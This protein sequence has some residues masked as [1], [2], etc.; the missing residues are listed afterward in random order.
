M[1]ELTH[2]VVYVR[3]LTTPVASS[4]SFHTS[5]TAH[6]LCPP[7]TRKLPVHCRATCC[8]WPRKEKKLLV[9]LNFPK[10]TSPRLTGNNPE[11]DP[12]ESQSGHLTSWL[13]YFTEPT[14]KF[15][16]STSIMPWPSPSKSFLI[17]LFIS[18][19]FVRRCIFCDTDA[20][21][22]NPRRK[23]RSTLCMSVRIRDFR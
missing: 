10:L 21:L 6:Q 3:N 23:R 1:T 17:S 8:L 4:W 9:A 18:R 14:D 13:R 5:V 15:W 11:C 12:F 20:S 2:R 16:D 7:H 22:D 19:R